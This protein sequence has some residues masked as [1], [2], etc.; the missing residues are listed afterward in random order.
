M[1]G[2]GLWQNATENGPFFATTF[3]DSNNATASYRTDGPPPTF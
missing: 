2:S 3:P 1:S